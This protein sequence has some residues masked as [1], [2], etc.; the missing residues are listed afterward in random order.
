MIYIPYIFLEALLSI[1]QTTTIK[2]NKTKPMAKAIIG[3][4]VMTTTA[5]ITTTKINKATRMTTIM[6]KTTPYYGNLSISKVVDYSFLAS[7]TKIRS[8]VEIAK[9]TIGRSVNTVSSVFENAIP[10]EIATKNIIVNMTPRIVPIYLKYLMSR[11]FSTAVYCYLE[12]AAYCFFALK[13]ARANI[14][15]EAIISSIVKAGNSIAKTTTRINIAKKM[16]GCISLNTAPIIVPIFE[17]L[18]CITGG[19]NG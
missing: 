14:N 12:I 2:A 10:T 17:S 13:I 18:P 6:D 9:I 1:M 19:V 5:T 15:I 4:S 7:L 8:E 3:N 11:V 16:N